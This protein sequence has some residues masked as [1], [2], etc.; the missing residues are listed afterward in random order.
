M[1]IYEHIPEVQVLIQVHDSLAGQF[2]SHRKAEMIERIKGV[3]RVAIP[4]DD[5]L[6]I[7]VGIN[8][9]DV[10]WGDC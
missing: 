10:S 3:S 7:P 2:P 1:N 4:Y 8:T 6:I 9:S 5:P